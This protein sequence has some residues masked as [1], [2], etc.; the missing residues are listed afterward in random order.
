MPRYDVTST[1]SAL[2][3][4][5]G[6]L[7]DNCGGKFAGV[8]DQFNALRFISPLW[9]LG[10]VSDAAVDR[11]YRTEIAPHVKAK[12]RGTL[13][14]VEKTDG[15]ERYLAR[16][17]AG[18]YVLVVWFDGPFDVDL[19]REMIAEALPEVEARTLDLPPSP[20]GPPHAAADKVRR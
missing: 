8:V 11:F 15:T 5:L 14:N 19:A 4:A 3:Q 17:F 13:L 2:T 7:V 9:A 6:L 16:S 18:I 12:G 10:K 1:H 20:Q